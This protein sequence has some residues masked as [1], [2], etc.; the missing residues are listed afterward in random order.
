MS[1]K[2]L[3]MILPLNLDTLLHPEHRGLLEGI[4]SEPEWMLAWVLYQWPLMRTQDSAELYDRLFVELEEHAHTVEDED[5]GKARF[6]TDYI[7]ENMDKFA[8][9]AQTV[10]STLIPFVGQIPNDRRVS[11]I[12]YDPFGKTD[13]VLTFDLLEV[14]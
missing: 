13:M 14:A 4:G 6:M 7:E 1:Q 3:R 10:Y 8:E 12:N 11:Q 5:E 9:T 2:Q